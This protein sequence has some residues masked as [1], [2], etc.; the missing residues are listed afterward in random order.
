MAFSKNVKHCRRCIAISRNLS[1]RAAGKDAG[2]TS[3]FARKISL[4][5]LN[6]TNKSKMSFQNKLKF[7]NQLKNLIN[8]SNYE[9]N[10]QFILNSEW[11][12]FLQKLTQVQMD[13]IRKYATVDDSK[14]EVQENAKKDIESRKPSQIG[15]P[16]IA[17]KINISSGIAIKPVSIIKN[18]F[19]E[20]KEFPLK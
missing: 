10:I 3:T 19:F 9:K 18:N 11:I 7:F 16:V 8:K 14:I 6:I 1:N 4:S 20:S 17:N 2:D 5:S 15:E 12:N 13:S